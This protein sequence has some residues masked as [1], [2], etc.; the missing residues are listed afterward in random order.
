MSSSWHQPG[1]TTRIQGDIAGQP[2]QDIFGNYAAYVTGILLIVVS[3]L[4][5][6][7]FQRGQ[8]IELGPV[9]IGRLRGRTSRQPPRK[10]TGADQHMLPAANPED[11]TRIYDV[12]NAAQF[13]G[14]IAVNY[15]QGNSVNLL[16]TH[17]EVIAV[18][19]RTRE[20]KPSAQ[21]LDLGG[22]TG[23][24]V[25]THFFNDSCIRWTYVDFSPAM[26]GQLQQ[27]LAGR[28]LYEN[29]Q[30]YVEDINQVYRRLHGKHYDI[31]LLNLVCSSMPEPPNFARLAQLIS[32]DGL[33]IV[34]DINPQYTYAHPYFKGTT[35]EGAKVAL[36]TRA[37]EPLDVLARARDAGLQL[38]EMK[39]I[40]DAELSYSY[41]AV[42][43][44]RVHPGGN[45][46][47][48]VGHLLPT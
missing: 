13:Y 8:P 2:L 34:S 16:A 7:A 40:G 11:V 15:D 35:A 47:G 31:V 39:K 44:N 43:A 3:I 6:W 26:V 45:H 33:L 36:S 46:Q 14:A 23:H 28:P 5:I 25:A 38:A 12:S 9:K 1:L 32:P 19:S 30:V 29:L 10:E 18:V 27:H 21:I 4:I 41:I 24:A 48:Q 17:M 42:F 37:V 20:T 22:G